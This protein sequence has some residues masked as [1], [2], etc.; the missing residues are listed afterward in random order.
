MSKQRDFTDGD[1]KKQLLAFSVPIILANMLQVSYQFIDSLWVGNLIGASALGSVGIASTVINVGLA[2]ILGINNA[3]LTVL[4]QQ[5]T[6]GDRE[7]LSRYLN[8]FVVLLSTLGTVAS[9]IGFILAE[10]ILSLLNTPETMMADATTYLQINSIGILFI[11]GY[12]FM[13]TILQ[14]LGDSVTPLKIVFVATLLNKIL[15]PLFDY[16]EPFSKRLSN[17]QPSAY[18]EGDNDGDWNDNGVG[19]GCQKGCLFVLFVHEDTNIL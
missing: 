9:V 13:G 1:I 7:G 16:P 5:R 17:I 3:T 4:S 19:N 8:A 6:K 12:N 18:E 2:F 11:I 14:A 15:D 10:N